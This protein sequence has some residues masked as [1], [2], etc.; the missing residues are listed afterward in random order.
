MKQLI[1]PIKFTVLESCT[2]L[3]AAKK[4]YTHT[5]TASTTADTT[6]GVKRS[7]G[8]SKRMECNVSIGQEVKVM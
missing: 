2:N 8:G 7:A 3:P 4:Q 5:P 1:M 6:V